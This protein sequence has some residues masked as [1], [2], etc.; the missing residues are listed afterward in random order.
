MEGQKM[1]GLMIRTPVSV[2]WSEYTDPKSKVGSSFN[3]FCYIL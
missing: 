2:I 3:K 1:S